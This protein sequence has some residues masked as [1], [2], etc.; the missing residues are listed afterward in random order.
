MNRIFPKRLGSCG[1]SKREWCD[2]RYRDIKYYGVFEGI[3][4]GLYYESIKGSA[5]IEKLWFWGNER[6]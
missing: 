1:Y 5:E 4:S 6:W 3:R 2:K